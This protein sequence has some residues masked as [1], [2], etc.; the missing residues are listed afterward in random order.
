MEQ[1]Y[2][3]GP[4][5]GQGL[6]DPSTEHDACG[7][8]FVVNIRGEKSHQIVRSGLEILVNL[9]HRGACGC[10][11]LTGDG[12]GILTQIPHEFFAAKTAELG[13]TLPAPGEYG[14]GVAFL[15]CDAKERAICE[16]EYEKAIAE[17]GQV[18]L[19]WRDVPVNNG[20]L[21][22]TALA[23]EPTIRQFFVARGKDTPA[24]MF[25]WKLFVIRKRQANAI[26][27]SD[28]AQK[29]YNYT[30]CLSSRTVI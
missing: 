18:M 4:P 28:L 29:K 26:A 11:P 15:P 24:D 19:G 7:V 20:V 3:Q 25:E 8:G 1:H 27:D 14:I 16:A 21:G 2:P 10:D 5:P 13:I 30:P 6:Y 17:E 22:P 23:V 12:A 9:T